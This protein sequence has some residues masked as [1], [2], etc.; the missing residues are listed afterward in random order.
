MLKSV[1][2]KLLICLTVFGLGI[3]PS[4]A[5]IEGGISK[6]HF[7]DAEKTLM[8]EINTDL[9]IK[10]GKY[11]E[12]NLFYMN[13]YRPLFMLSNKD[14]Y[15]LM[16]EKKASVIQRITAPSVYNVSLKT[17]SITKPLPVIPSIKNDTVKKKVVKENKSDKA[18]IDL[19]S[20]YEQAKNRGVDSDQ[21]ID[22]AL[23]LKKTKTASNC[24][25]AMDLLNDVTKEE[26]FNAYAFY[27][28]GEICAQQSDSENAM[29]NYLEALRLNPCSKQSCLGIA[30]ILEPTNKELAQ[31]YYAR[32]K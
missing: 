15:N 10:T 14:L 11:W 9:T 21:K 23:T 32:A 27:I 5:K 17:A 2:K 28:K 6:H 20:I 30:K 3:L 22:A 25:L 29:K 7:Y 4:F 8:P 18:D 13:K 31:K 16:P 12:K 26:P 19:K 24:N 1:I